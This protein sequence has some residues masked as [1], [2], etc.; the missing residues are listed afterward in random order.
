MELCYNSNKKKLVID[1]DNID[2]S[3][4]FYTKY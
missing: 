1:L 4:K 2:V 3:I